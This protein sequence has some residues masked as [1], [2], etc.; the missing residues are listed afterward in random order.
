MTVYDQMSSYRAPKYDMHNYCTH[1][2]KKKKKSFSPDEEKRGISESTDFLL[3]R[4]IYY[5]NNYNL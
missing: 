2:K 4:N 3:H 1:K 5:S